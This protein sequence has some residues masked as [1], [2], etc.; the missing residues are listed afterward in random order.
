MRLLK[1]ILLPELP[2]L[3][4]LTEALTKACLSE[5]ALT[6]SFFIQEDWPKNLFQHV[7]V[8][9]C[10]FKKCNFSA[11]SLRKASFLNVIFENCDFSNARWPE[12]RFERVEF[13]NCKLLGTDLTASLWRH[14]L[15]Q[16]VNGEYA[17]FTEGGIQT[18][19]FSH[20][21]LANASISD[22]AWKSLQFQHCNLTSCELLHTSLKGLD[23]RSC[24]LSG[25]KLAGPELQGAIV[26]S[27]QAVELARFLGIVID[28]N[29]SNS[30]PSHLPG[31]LQPPG[32]RE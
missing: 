12:C 4:P 27:F 6:D 14:V 31:T 29:L 21:E 1:P 20:C 24:Q 26:T 32:S 30:Q 16:E 3:L 19:L 2:A 11:A 22:C 9:G 18:L 10:H 23:L 28:D 17:N 13:R 25:L 7:N 15:M 8:Q 5:E